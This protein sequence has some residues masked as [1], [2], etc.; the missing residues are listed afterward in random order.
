[1]AS[2]LEA[3]VPAPQRRDQLPEPAEP[4]RTLHLWSIIKDMVTCRQCCGRCCPPLHLQHA[5]T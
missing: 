2:W 4:L 5:A 1:M 3:E